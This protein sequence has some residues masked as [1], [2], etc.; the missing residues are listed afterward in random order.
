MKHIV[1]P[2]IGAAV[3]RRDGDSGI[4]GA[5]L[6][7]VASGLVK[8]TAKLGLLAALGLGAKALLDRSRATEATHR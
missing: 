2:L 6:G 5:F 7:Y 4:K 8:T 3:D 1:G